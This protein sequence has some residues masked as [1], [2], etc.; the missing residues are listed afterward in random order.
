MS[1]C[2][3]NKDTEMRYPSGCYVQ[4]SVWAREFLQ[5]PTC[6]QSTPTDWGLLGSEIM[7]S[8]G[9]G[10]GSRCGADLMHALADCLQRFELISLSLKQGVILLSAF[11]GILSGSCEF[12][13]GGEKPLLRMCVPAHC[14]FLPPANSGFFP[15]L[16][17]LKVLSGTAWHS[18]VGPRRQA[19]SRSSVDL[20]SCDLKG[21]QASHLMSALLPE[22]SVHCQQQE[23]MQGS[24]KLVSF[25]DV[26]VDFS[27]EEWQVMDIGQRTLYKEVMLETYSNLVFLGYCGPKPKLIV[28]LEQGGVR[29]R[30]ASDKNFTDVQEMED[31]IETC[32]ESP[33]ECLCE[34]AVMNS[35]TVEERVRLV[36]TFNL[37]STHKPELMRNNGNSLRMRTEE[38]TE[39]QNMLFNSEPHEIHAA[40]RTSVSPVVEQS[41]KYSEHF[42]QNYESTSEQQ[43][44]EYGEEGKVLNSETIFFRHNCVCVGE[45][46]YNHSKHREDYDKSTVLAEEILQGWRKTLECTACGKTFYLRPTVTTHQKTYTGENPFTC[47]ECEESLSTE[48]YI[49]KPQSKYPKKSDECIPCGKSQKS[50]LGTNKRTQTEDKPKCGKAFTQKEFLSDPQRTCTGKKPYECNRCGKSFSQKKYL[51]VHHRTHTGEK[52]FKCSKCEKSFVQKALLTI[53]QRT[54]TGEKPYGCNKCGKSFTRKSDFNR[55]KII[56]TGDKPY[57]CKKCGK[58]FKRRS[59]LGTHNNTHTGEKP[60]KCNKCG[61]SFTQSSHLSRHKI[62][63]TGEKPYECNKCGKSFRRKSHVTS[64]Q[65]THTGE[66]PY[67]CKKCGK[68]FLLRS[69]L[70]RHNRIHMG[71]T[72]GM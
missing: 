58:S 61:K 48:I 30:E 66:K 29:R 17:L 21:S 19:P 9:R 60:Y 63:H 24:L 42:T 69:Y 62:I 47:S 68:T 52:P 46:S 1:L 11:W 38:F 14:W 43:Y 51:S 32:Q 64:H 72:L 33:D 36:T 39:C 20:G 2:D 71:E 5:S 10:E 12:L 31:V 18:I 28:K 41:L 7:L 37:S 56:H 45:S 55:H 34:V 57:E 22:S 59:Y 53:H 4:A 40:Y 65:R 25:D 26:A 23:R 44:F 13:G 6:K 15:W 54:H 35:N 27:W 49:I 67:E 16:W 3:S 70:R 50:A 8:E